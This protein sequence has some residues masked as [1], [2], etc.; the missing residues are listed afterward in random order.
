MS[1]KS[2]CFPVIVDKELLNL[3]N[4]LLTDEDIKALWRLKK[5]YGRTVDAEAAF[6][7]D[8]LKDKT[9]VL[10]MHRWWSLLDDIKNNLK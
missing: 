4:E 5:A 8:E 2:Y 10:L 9:P 6:A 3:I 7:A 1:E